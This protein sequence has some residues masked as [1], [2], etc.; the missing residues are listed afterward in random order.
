M[1]TIPTNITIWQDLAGDNKWR[2]EFLERSPGTRQL[3]FGPFDLPNEARGWVQEAVAVALPEPDQWQRT[4]V[5][6][7][8]DEFSCLIENEVPDV[9]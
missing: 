4:I 9:D 3:E 7:L 6:G 1:T 8:R 2:V 5:N